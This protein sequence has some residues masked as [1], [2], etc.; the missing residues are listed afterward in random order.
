MKNVLKSKDMSQ[1]V[2]IV[3]T[4]I[5]LVIFFSIMN[6]AYISYDNIMTVLLST[7]VN[8]M[9]AIGVSFVIITSGIDI[10][11]GTVMTLSCVM[12]GTAFSVWGWPLWLAILFGFLVGALCGAINGIAVTKMCLWSH[13]AGECVFSEYRKI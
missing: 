6:P 8:G 5:L 13:N 2:I 7:C 4:F 12:S 9:L 10:S 11:V 3:G 1:K